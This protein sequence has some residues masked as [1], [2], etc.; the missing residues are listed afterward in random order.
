MYKV[1][2]IN[3]EFKMFIGIVNQCN[4]NNSGVFGLKIKFR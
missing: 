3:E 4:H 1:E 2:A